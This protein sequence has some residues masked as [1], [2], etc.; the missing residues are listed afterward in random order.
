M[1]RERLTAPETMTTRGVDIAIDCSG[2]TSLFRP[3]LCLSLVI[4]VVYAT[5]LS[6]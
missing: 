4:Y 2:Y 6:A 1:V 3:G 5:T